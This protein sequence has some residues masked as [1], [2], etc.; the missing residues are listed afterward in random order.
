MNKALTQADLDELERPIPV[1]KRG[2]ERIEGL[3]HICPRSAC[4]P[5]SEAG[6]SGHDMRYKQENATNG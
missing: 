5:P 3:R 1:G 6:G 4:P 2:A